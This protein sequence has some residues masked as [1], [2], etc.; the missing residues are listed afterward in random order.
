MNSRMDHHRIISFFC[1]KL[2]HI[3]RLRVI[4]TRETPQCASLLMKI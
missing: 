4:Q 3:D 2:L 1:L